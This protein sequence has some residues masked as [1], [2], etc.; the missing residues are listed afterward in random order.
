MA[1][2]RVSDFTQ[3]TILS[4]DGDLSFLLFCPTL[5]EAVLEAE[6]L[7]LED[8]ENSR[9]KILGKKYQYTWFDLEPFA[10]CY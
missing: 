8:R 5:L 7:P 3:Q 1:T 10:D 6:S 2:Y 9:F 4:R